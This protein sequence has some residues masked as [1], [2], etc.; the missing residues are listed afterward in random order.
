MRT[1]RKIRFLLLLLAC[2]GLMRCGGDAGSSARSSSAIDFVPSFSPSSSE[3]LTDLVVNTFDDAGYAISVSPESVD[4]NDEEGD[5]A[6]DD[7]VTREFVLTNDSGAART[8]KF[9]LYAVS[10]GFSILDE[11]KINLGAWDEI[12]LQD[13]ESR[14]FYARFNAWLF[15]TQTTYI[16]VTADIDGYI[17]LPLRASVSGASDFR[18][19]PTGYLCSDTEAPEV[20]YLD[21]LKVA[22]GQ[23]ETQGIKLCNTGGED[24]EVSAVEI[25]TATSS[26]RSRVFDTDAYEEFIWDVEDE[27]NS[28]FAMG[29]E[30]AFSDSFAEPE[31]LDAPTT[32]SDG[33]LDYAVKIHETQESVDDVIVAAGK[34]LTLDVNLTPSLDYE[35]PA[36]ALYEPVDRNARLRIKT[37]LG[38]IDIPLVGATSGKE[39]VL[40]MSYRL[41]DTEVWR[42]V[43]LSSDGATVYFGS[44]ATFKDWVTDNFKAAEILIE[45]IGS[46]SKDLEFY[47]ASLAGYFEYYDEDGDAPRFPIVIP[48]GG[49]GE[50]F[51]LRYLPTPSETVTTATWDFGQFYFEHTGGNGPY[52]KLAL[53]GEEESGYAVELKFG[54][55]ELEREYEDTESKYFCAMQIADGSAAATPYSLTVTNNNK[56]HDLTVTWSVAEDDD[57]EGSFTATADSGQITVSKN[58]SESFEIQLLADA[59]TSEGATIRGLL[60]VVASYPAS[61]EAQYAAQLA[62]LEGREFNVPFHAQASSTG[63]CT[64]G[65]GSVVGADSTST[66]QATIIVDRISMVLTSLTETAQNPPAFKFHLPV[67]IDYANNRVR[68][69]EAIP[70]VYDKDSPDFTPIKQFRSYAHQITNINGCAPKPTNPYRLE[71]EKGSW[72]GDGY[73]CNENGEVTFSGKDGASYTIDTDT[74]CLPSNGGEEVEV[75]GVKWVVFYQDFVKF[76]TDSCALQYYGKIATFAYRPDLETFADVF[77]KSE[78]SPNESEE[79]YEGIYGSFKYDSYI[80]FNEKTSC[81]AKTYE[82]GDSETDP[83]LVK[84]CY[85][86]IA[87]K[88]D[89]ARND[90]LVNE[91]AYFNFIIDEGVVPSDATS[92]SPNTDNWTGYGIYE[93]HAD[94]TGTYDTKYDITLYNVHAQAFALSPADRFSFFQHPGHLLFSELYVTFT[95]KPVADQNDTSHW[96]DLIA[97][98]TRPN[99]TKDQVYLDS[100]TTDVAKFWTNSSGSYNDFNNLFSNVLEDEDLESGV[101]YGGYGKGNYR[102][103]ES[104][105][106]IACDIIPAGWPVNFDENNLLLLVGVGSFNGKGNTAP[107]FAREDSTGQGKSLYFALHGCLVEGEPSTTQGCYSYHLDDDRMTYDESTTND[108]TLVIDEYKSH[109]MLPAG[110]PVSAADCVNFAALPENDPLNVLYDPYKYMSCINYK[111]LPQDRDRLT[112]YYDSDK[113]HYEDDDYKSSTCGYGM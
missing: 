7:E 65:G 38:K 50:N 100:S 75:D 113:F 21:F 93:P 101:D 24:I 71:F 94:E 11:N 67:E 72:T 6:L 23:T 76:D 26:Q 85:A 103:C 19:I 104:G 41:A 1:P 78:A 86:A 57:S 5:I 56:E 98:E 42:E 58:S 28:A 64:L 109:G 74:A 112:N 3:S 31:I 15:G 12:T 77:A 107:G 27:I 9:A 17:Q 44:V 4:F 20:T 63:E 46:G 102:L 66:V 30:P 55:S 39:P 99:F 33:S 106:A 54:G 82:A 53:V 90:G 36:G 105:G 108:T 60:N 73:D 22:H 37:S 52:G 59:G 89:N 96:D 110:Y 61:V 95:T 32:D 87:E 40:K 25:T 84:A 43:D 91:C 45:N 29:L 47:P 34:I 83:D 68:V 16:T 97:V 81:A 2:L 48:A 13:G 111:I 80:F 8:F 88:T 92:A 10:S 70:F 51:G 79:F 49:S 14:T 18:I 35:A 69:S 62:G